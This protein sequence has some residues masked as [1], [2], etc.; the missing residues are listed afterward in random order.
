MKKNVSGQTVGAQMTTAADGSPFTGSV[1]VYI[2]GDNGSQGAGSV[3]AGACTHKGKGYHSYAPSQ[4]ETNF[5]HVAFTFEGTGA[6][7]QTVQERPTT[8]LA[9][10]A[11]INA[12]TTNL[13]SDPADASDIAASFASIA[14]LIG[15]SQDILDKLDT[16]L[17]VTSPGWRYTI[18]ALA[19]GVAG[20]TAAWV[21]GEGLD[22]FE[23]VMKQVA[24]PGQGMTGLTVTAE[25]FNGTEFEPCENSPTEITSGR[26]GYVIDFTAADSLASGTRCA[27][28]RMSAAGALDTFITLIL[29]E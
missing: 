26:G 20:I 12:K 21:V 11:A 17:E 23:F 13:P 19:N 18:E 14:A 6:I 10:A 2:T 3:G 7:T 1:T 4:G 16:M 25:R 22:G 27:L 8:I 28:F 9:D 24:N 15:A 29:A 5:D